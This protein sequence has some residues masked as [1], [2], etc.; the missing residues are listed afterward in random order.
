MRISKLEEL[1][2]QTSKRS[3][4]PSMTPKVNRNKAKITKSIN[5][6]C[7]NGSVIDDVISKDKFNCDKN[8]NLNQQRSKFKP[9][10]SITNCESCRYKGLEKKIEKFQSAN[11]SKLMLL[12]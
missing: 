5:S 9:I 3:T 1:Q 12:K 10:T 2:T 6:L 7:N 4:T 11:R 8:L